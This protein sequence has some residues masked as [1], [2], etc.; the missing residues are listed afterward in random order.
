MQP[1]FATVE[2]RLRTFKKWPESSPIRPE[3]LAEAGFYTEGKS[4]HA[5]CFYCGGGLKDWEEGDDPW[6][7]HARWFSQCAFI[8]MHKGRHFVARACQSGP[9]VLP[10][11]VIFQF[12]NPSPF[13]LPILKTVSELLNDRSGKPEPEE[14][15]DMV[16]L[17]CAASEPTLPADKYV[18][19]VLIFLIFFIVSFLCLG[20]SW[21]FAKFA[22]CAIGLSCSSRA[23]ILWLVLRV[24]RRC[25]P[26]RCVGNHSK[27]QYGLTYH[28]HFTWE[29]SW[30][31]PEAFL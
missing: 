8:T 24:R 3:A 18:N 12:N 4:D 9:A 15:E 21:R 11:S 26:V 27:A 23:G 1:D 28:R 17:A 20:R 2:A 31:I 13:L 16:G 5:L 10:A 30:K 29:R 25:L 7:E 14:S 22:M 19:C 6:I